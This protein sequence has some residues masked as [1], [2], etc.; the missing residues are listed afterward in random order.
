MGYVLCGGAFEHPR[1]YRTMYLG[2]YAATNLGD[3]RSNATVLD[4]ARS[5]TITARELTQSLCRVSVG[6]CDD[7]TSS[8]SVPEGVAPQHIVEP[9]AGERLAQ[10]VSSVACSNS[11]ASLQNG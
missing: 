7:G 8:R 5:N 2:A 4:L 3:N 6:Q 10:G 1:I 9:T 11:I